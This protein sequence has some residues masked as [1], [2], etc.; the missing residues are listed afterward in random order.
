MAA[1]D[2]LVNIG[3]AADSKKIAASSKKDSSAMKTIAVLTMLFLPATFVAVSSSI[4]EVQ[5]PLTR[6]F[7]A[8]F[9]MPLL[10]WDAKNGSSVFKARFKYYWA[11]TIP[12]TFILILVWSLIL[13]LPWKRWVLWQDSRSET[14]SLRSRG[15]DS[16]LDNDSSRSL[17]D[18]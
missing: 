5:L 13:L 4:Q 9:A 1:K 16:V 3:L 6:I 10:D 18:D 7:Q 14:S 11:V 2:N 12:L 8:L 17:V 15:L